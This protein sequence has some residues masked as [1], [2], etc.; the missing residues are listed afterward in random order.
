VKTYKLKRFLDEEFR[1]WLLANIGPIDDT[2]AIGYNNIL[3]I[4]KDSDATFFC[5]SFPHMIKI[6]SGERN[7]EVL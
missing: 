4:K 5:L 6:E 2:W 1:D 3:T 7:A